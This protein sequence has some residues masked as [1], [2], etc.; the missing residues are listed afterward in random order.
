MSQSVLV[1]Y[2]GL[3]HRFST[4]P[5]IWSPKTIV[6]PD[7]LVK[8]PLPYLTLTPIILLTLSTGLLKASVPGG[9]IANFEKQW[10]VYSPAVLAAADGVHLAGRVQRQR[11]VLPARDLAPTGLY[12]CERVAFSRCIDGCLAFFTRYAYEINKIQ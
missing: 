9:V 7:L 4:F 10:S 5:N 8:L 6:T 12:G 2:V 1:L 11:V 3:V